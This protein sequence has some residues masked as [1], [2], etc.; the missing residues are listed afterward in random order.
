MSTIFQ[1]RTIPHNKITM[2]QTISGGEKVKE[3]CIKKNEGV[4][5]DATDC[6]H[7]VDGCNCEMNTIKVSKGDAQHAHFCRTY[8]CNCK[9][10]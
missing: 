4:C 2:P 3:N 1:P 7:N 5:C 6:V 10:N 9:E 8:E